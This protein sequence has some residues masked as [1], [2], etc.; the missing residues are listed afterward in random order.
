[1]GVK[2]RQKPNGSGVWWVFIHYKSQRTSLKVGS[3]KAARKTAEMI[4]AK[5]KLGQFVLPKEK[6]KE[7]PP[8]AVPTLKDYYCR[9]ERTYFQNA[10]REKS[11]DNY[12]TSFR[13]YILPPLG[14]L[15]LAEISRQQILDLIA[16]L[17]EK[18]YMRKIRKK[19]EVK[20]GEDPYMMVN[21]KFA[22]D[23]MRLILAALRTVFNHAREER[24]ISD[25]PAASVGKFFKQAKR[26]HERI[27]PLTFEE[28][29]IFLETA[30]DNFR[31]HYPVFLCAIH[32]GMRSGELAGLQWGDVDF[33]GKFLIARRSIVNGRINPT[34]TDK[35]RR[36][37]LSDELLAALEELRRRRKEEWLAS[38][39]N[40]IPEWVFC[41]REGKPAD[42]QN[43]KNR[44]FF[45]CLEMAKLR[46]IRF[47]D[48]RHTFAS[49]LIQNGEGL[50]YVKEQMGHS[51]IKI[52]VDIYGHLVPSANR[53]AVNRLP[54]LRSLDKTDQSKKI[55]P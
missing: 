42:M 50:A 13:L 18:G 52:T 8:P 54:S 47:H 33:N 30:F 19:G 21:Q 3:E 5:L 31:V 43:I 29:P 40:E 36:I 24:I 2:L 25:N 51:S 37:D 49:L 34:K 22:K 14:H 27:E 4:E 16:D 26:V 17:Q 15:T 41:N 9:V 44:F 55:C 20:S 35:Q 53:Q 7:Q 45:R 38:G 28:V 23:S 1:M 11:R 48:L 32:T 12:E 46:R 6:P 39:K 10:L